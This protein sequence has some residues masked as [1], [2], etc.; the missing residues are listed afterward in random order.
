MSIDATDLEAN[1]S[2]KSIVRKDNGDKWRECLRKLYEAEAGKSNPDDEELRRFDKSRKPRKMVSNEE[3]E[4]E[5]DPDSRIGQMKDG[6]YH[7]KYRPES[8]CCIPRAKSGS[9]V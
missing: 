1:A 6:R 4:S 3:W 5:T 8:Q 7:L 2:L 9:G